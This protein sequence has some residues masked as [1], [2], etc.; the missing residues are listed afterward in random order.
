MAIVI[1]R[2]MFFSGSVTKSTKVVLVNVIHFIS[3]WLTPFDDV[4][5][6]EFTNEA[7]QTVTAQMMNTETEMG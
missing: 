5:E 2:P 7:G 3:D 1:V 4:R 6:G